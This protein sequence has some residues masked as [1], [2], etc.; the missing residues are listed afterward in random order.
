MKSPTIAAVLAQFLFA[1]LPP[2][3]G[4]LLDAT[5]STAAPLWF[6]AILWLAIIAALLLFR[7]LQHR[8]APAPAA[9]AS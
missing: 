4:H 9:P 2:V 7:R 3:A 1:L 6:G 8:A 5:R